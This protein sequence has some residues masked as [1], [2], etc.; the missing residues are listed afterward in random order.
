MND[1]A[2]E[3]VEDLV[4][5]GLRMA[6]ER[7][8]ISIDILDI[9][10]MLERKYSIVVPAFGPRDILQA[11]T[12]NLTRSN[13]EQAELEVDQAG[14]SASA[15]DGAGNG[16]AILKAVGPASNIHIENIG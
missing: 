14:D 8:Q 5:G 7:G 3:F 4:N 9:A 11:R 2:Q 13:Q 16:K 6:R 1:L 12:L 15:G 10:M